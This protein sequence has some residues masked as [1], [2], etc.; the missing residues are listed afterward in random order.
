LAA[1]LRAPFFAGRFFAT[2]LAFF[3]AGF[4]ALFVFVFFAAM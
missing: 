3:A 1:F 4:F 2:L